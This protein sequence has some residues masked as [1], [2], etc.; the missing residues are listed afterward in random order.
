MNVANVQQ[1]NV[2]TGPVA[3]TSAGIQ[4]PTKGV[5]G[6]F[7]IWFLS[8]LALAEGSVTLEKF[9]DEKVNKP[10]IVELRNKV[11][12]RLVRE[13]KFGGRVQVTMKD[14]TEYTGSAEHPKG[15]PDN[16]MSFEELSQKFTNSA[17]HAIPEKNFE[18]VIDL[19]NNLEKLKNVKSIIKLMER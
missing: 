16:P 12:A 2:Q 18:P 19:I 4:T 9:T 17:R 5:E 11:D 1:I 8:A 13:L 14:G 10:E 3:F 7:S 6:K 15:G